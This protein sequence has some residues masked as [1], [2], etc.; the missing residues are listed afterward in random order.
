VEVEQLG[1]VG[2]RV[3]ARLVRH[4]DAALDPVGLSVPQYRVLGFLA[5]GETAS[6]KLASSMAVS[7]PSVTAVV[8]GLV[9]RGLV[10]RG[11]DATDRRRLP[12]VLTG[13]GRKLLA[14]A[15]AAVG[16]RLDE[17]LGHLDDRR[18]GAARTS[19][20]HW[21]TGL[22]RHRERKL[23]ERAQAA[24]TSATRTASAAP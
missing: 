22:D 8:D 7:P 12:L 6:S 15:N 17:I 13:A 21:Q 24:Q 20:S 3:V 5:E 18:A 10:E 14:Q 9:A 1:A 19:L 2:G 23:E 4:L 16:A 11:A